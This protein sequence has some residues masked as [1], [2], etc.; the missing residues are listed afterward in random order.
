MYIHTYTHTYRMRIN[1]RFKK[2]T[3]HFPIK[4]SPAI[5]EERLDPSWGWRKRTIWKRVSNLSSFP[6][7]QVQCKNTQCPEIY[8]CKDRESEN[9]HNVILRLLGKFFNIH[10]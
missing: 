6:H 2:K 9:I 3:V 8:W 10:R 7:I 5:Y 1:Q 4:H